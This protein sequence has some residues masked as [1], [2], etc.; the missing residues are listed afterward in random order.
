MPALRQV[1]QMLAASW[2]GAST[3]LG[4]AEQSEAEVAP[5]FVYLVVQ[6]L[7]AG[8]LDRAVVRATI[9]EY[10]RVTRRG[11]WDGTV[12]GSRAAWVR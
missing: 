9:K 12:G 1:S 7:P 2:G 8:N 10:R 6:Q 4:V 3:V 5:V 11:E